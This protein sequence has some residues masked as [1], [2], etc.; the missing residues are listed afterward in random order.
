MSG[1]LPECP[2][3]NTSAHP[4]DCLCCEVS[5]PCIC[6]RLRACEQRV[7]TYFTA[8]IKDRMTDSDLDD[9]V[10]DDGKDSIWAAIDELLATFLAHSQAPASKTGRH[11]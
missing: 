10:S 1:H 4:D 8:R 2:C 5:S 11:P 3:A 6:D 7:L 9:V